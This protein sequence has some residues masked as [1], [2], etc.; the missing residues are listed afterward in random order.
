[1]ARIVPQSPTGDVA[2]NQVQLNTKT[3]LA[4]MLRNRLGNS[5]ANGGNM[6]MPAVDGPNLVEPSAA[7]TLRMMTAQHNSPGPQAQQQFQADP[8]AP[9]QFQ[10]IPIQP[11]AVQKPMPHANLIVTS[12]KPFPENVDQVISFLFHPDT[13]EFTHLFDSSNSQPLPSVE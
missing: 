6:P 9:P 3:E 7:G 8:N 13:S 4:N 5:G 2:T 11:G 1:M 12:Q 10:R